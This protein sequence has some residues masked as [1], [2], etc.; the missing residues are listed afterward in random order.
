VRHA[1]KVGRA[2][3]GASVVHHAWHGTQGTRD[4]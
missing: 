2:R 4:S 1:G 3:P